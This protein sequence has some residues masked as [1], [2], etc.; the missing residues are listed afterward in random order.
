VRIWDLT[1][2]TSIGGPLTDHTSE[3]LEVACTMLDDRPLA[4]TG[5]YNGTVRIW[6]LTTRTSIGD[7]LTGHTSWVAAVACTMLDG[8]PVAVTGSYN[9]TV[10]IW[11]LETRR[12]IDRIDLP[13]GVRKIDLTPA[14]EIVA[15]L[16][17][18]FVLLERTSDAKP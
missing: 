1:T 3:L 12:Q 14:C 6:D 15:A 11:D 4:V 7:P 8:R 16:G 13:S 18:D 10:R 9:G 5:S 17:W 2:G